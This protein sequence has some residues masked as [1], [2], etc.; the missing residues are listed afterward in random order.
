MKSFISAVLISGLVTTL[1]GQSAI[2]L[3]HSTGEGVFVEGKVASWINN[4]NSANKTSYSVTE[5][6]FPDTPYPWENYPYDYWNLWINGQCNTT[7]PNI[8]CLNTILQTYDAVIFK[9]CFPGAGIAADNATPS[10]SSPLKTLA[11]YKLQYRA[12]RD[13]MDQYPAKKFIVWTLAPLHRLETTTQEAARAREFVNWVKS[14]WLTEDGKSHPNIFIFD[15]FGLVAES[16][17]T[18]VNGKV[19]CLKYE[20]EKSHTVV[21]S[22]PN[23]LANT[24][25][26]PIFAQFVVNTLKG[27][28]TG[29]SNVDDS[30]GGLILYPNP[31]N[32]Q[33]T[34]D[35]SGIAKNGDVFSVDIFNL[36]GNQM[37]S[38]KFYNDDIFDIDIRS[39]A[40]GLYIIR[41][42]NGNQ[43]L[44]RR[45]TIADI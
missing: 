13:L 18:P 3:H 15:F 12:L 11:N 32:E 39:F 31:G 22:H 30:T 2:F 28:A 23:T 33:L 29:I 44:T 17:P 43:V 1:N 36:S 42:I 27:Q 14:G 41:I 34:L 38:K 37:L 8:Q 6:P 7:N 4:Y 20:Y 45:F 24:T 40:R 19:N 9:H 25:V 5:R 16:N 26:G 21:D 10:V 35:L